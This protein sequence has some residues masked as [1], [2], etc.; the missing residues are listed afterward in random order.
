[1]CRVVILICKNCVEPIIGT[2][3]K[4]NLGWRF[5]NA[6]CP[7]LIKKSIEGN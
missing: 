1:M 3:R 5:K 4:W 7:S 2:N 6:K